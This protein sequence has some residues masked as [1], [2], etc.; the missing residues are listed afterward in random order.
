MLAHLFV[1]Q[2]VRV[3]GT[4]MVDTLRSGDIVFVTRFDYRGGRTPKRGDIVHCRFPN[5]SG[6]YIK[7]M[8]GLPGDT[9]EIIDSRVYINGESLSEPY[10]TGASEDY[11]VTLGEDEYLV[12]GDNRAESYDSRAADMGFISAEDL[13]GKVRLVLWPFRTIE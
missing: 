6:T 3:E 11:S 7:R 5:R 4:S 8:I 9:V 2:A 1:F 13:L 12:L 10:A